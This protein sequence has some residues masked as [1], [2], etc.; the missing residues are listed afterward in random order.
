MEQL[1][2]LIKS[3]NK[4]EKKMVRKFLASY[5]SNG[6]SDTVSLQLFDLLNKRKRALSNKDCS[7]LLFG[8]DEKNRIRVL[9]SRVKQKVLDAISTNIVIENQE[10]EEVTKQS[11]TLRKKLMQ[12]QLLYYSKKGG[13]KI[14]YQLLDELIEKAT[15]YE[16]YPILVDA[17]NMKKVVVGFRKG[18]DSYNSLAKKA[19][20]ALENY[21]VFTGIVN[22]YYQVL[23]MYR[24]NTHTKK[25]IL[26]FYKKV[27]QEAE[28]SIQLSTSMNSLYYVNVIKYAYYIE[29]KDYENAHQIMLKQLKLIQ[30][31]IAVYRKRRLGATYDYLCQTN[32][33]LRNYKDSISYARKGKECFKKGEL[34][35]SVAE[36]LEFRSFLYNGDLKWAEKSILEII[37]NYKD[38]LDAHRLSTHKFFLANLYF[39]KKD[40]KKCNRLLAEQYKFK[41]DR[42]GW[43][44]NLKLLNIMS[45]ADQNKMEGA[46][47]IYN[48][49]NRLLDKH[50]K[51]GEK[52][53][54][55]NRI[56]MQVL[57][58]WLSN[59]GNKSIA[60]MKNSPLL[61]KFSAKENHWDPLKSELIPFDVWFNQ[62]V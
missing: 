51:E 22:A 16:L 17:L 18:E 50:K 62:K 4:S 24:I 10:L 34:N 54:S 21:K 6:K 53:T 35:Y 32:I 23:F 36:E 12:F 39:A 25:D 19:E 41:K 1:Q 48:N 28:D 43:E 55:R 59:G 40:Y 5:S 42:T 56:I 44:F 57:K 60:K 33:V 2:Q 3:L 15:K 29:K 61:Q 26:S 7:E 20:E 9:K 47:T 49:L 31:H 38:E 37:K 11:I 30:E 8:R 27:I 13:K 58:Q 52:L 46:Y 45:L 14:Q